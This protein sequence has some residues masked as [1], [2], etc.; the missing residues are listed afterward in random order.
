MWPYVLAAVAAGAM[1]AEATATKARIALHNTQHVRLR[2]EV[3]RAFHPAAR[4]GSVRPMRIKPA[5]HIQRLATAA[6]ILEKTQS[7]VGCKMRCPYPAVR[8]L[9]E[10][11]G[12]AAYVARP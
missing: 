10:L 7:E 6:S 1:A 4:I 8:R 3:C 2:G 9:L 5:S 12:A 11:Y